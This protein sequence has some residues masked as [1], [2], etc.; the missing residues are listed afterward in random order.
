MGG[1]LDTTKQRKMLKEKK[2]FERSLI[3]LSVNVTLN[4]LKDTNIHLHII[5]NS[6]AANWLKTEQ[7]Q[8]ITVKINFIQLAFH[9]LILRCHRQH[10]V[11]ICSLVKM[12]SKCFATTEQNSF[13]IMR[14]I[15]KFVAVSA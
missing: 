14:K 1:V 15:E 4:N 11:K 12:D 5:S 6:N 13:Y 3:H 7:I 2:T 9:L 10:G 8:T